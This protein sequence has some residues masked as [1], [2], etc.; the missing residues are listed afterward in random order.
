MSDATRDWPVALKVNDAASE[1]APTIYY[2]AH[3]VYGGSG[4][5]FEALTPDD[6]AY[7]RDVAEALLRTVAPSERGKKP[8]FKMVSA[9]AATPSDNKSN[10]WVSNDAGEVIQLPIL[11]GWC[12]QCHTRQASKHDAPYCSDI[13]RDAARRDALMDR[14]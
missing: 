13:C 7:Y 10:T 9:V 14:R 1:L 12:P 2:L 4:K 5:M 11:P 8:Y 3:R 6:R